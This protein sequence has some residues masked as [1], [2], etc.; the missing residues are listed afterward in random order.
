MEAA[1]SRYGLKLKRVNKETLRGR[2]PLPSH[3]SSASAQSFSINTAKNA[4]ACQSDSCAKARDGRRGGNVLDFVAAMERCGV[5]D[6]A[7]KLQ[8]WFGVAPPGAIE[9]K[10]AGETPP[11]ERVQEPEPQE[12]NKP[13]A[14][15]LGGIDPS[16][17]YLAT[18]G[19]SVETA[20]YFGAGFFPGRGSMAGRVVFPIHNKDAQ[21]VAY[22]G[23]SIDETEP[24]WKFP[25]GFHKGQELY[26]L[27]RAIQAQNKLVVLV[28]GFFGCIQVCQSWYPTVALMGSSLSAMQEALICAH[29]TGA[30]LLFDGDPAGRQCTNDCLLRLGPKIWVKAILLPDG[31]QPDHFTPT[32]LAQ[33]IG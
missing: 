5:R 22:A 20:Q 17:P 13:L 7:L 30:Y 27:H 32:E 1:I 12:P 19:V 9:P 31:K 25:P 16:H 23:R 26:N 10:P 8:E 14:F 4:W 28:E 21:L 3:S 29:F 18:R 24:R 11:K 6:A 2:C 33:I 15:E